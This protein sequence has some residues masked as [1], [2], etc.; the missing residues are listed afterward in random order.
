MKQSLKIAENT[1]CTIGNA[2]DFFLIGFIKRKHVANTVE[3]FLRINADALWTEKLLKSIHKTFS[4][5]SH[6]L[7][8]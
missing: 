1:Y 2:I 8:R 7:L 6:L 5:D 4:I 3:A